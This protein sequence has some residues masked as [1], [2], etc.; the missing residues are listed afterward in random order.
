MSTLNRVA[1]DPSLR[2]ETGLLKP[3]GAEPDLRDIEKIDER[4]ECEDVPLFDNKEVMAKLTRIIDQL[5]DLKSIK[6]DEPAGQKSG[7][8]VKHSGLAQGSGEAGK[9]LAQ[10]SKKS[11]EINSANKV[12]TNN[13]QVAQAI[14]KAIQKMIAEINEKGFIIHPHGTFKMFWDPIM[15]IA[16]LWSITVSPLRISIWFAEDF[17]F[18]DVGD[19]IVDLLFLADFFLKFFTGFYQYGRLIKKKRV[20]NILDSENRQALHEE[21]IRLLDRCRD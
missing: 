16:L 5:G 21:Q 15:A 6:I 18:V 19:M 7:E 4:L 13:E 11:G 8:L 17:I 12:D 10:L 1:P 14:N 9:E 3:A 20:A 2:G